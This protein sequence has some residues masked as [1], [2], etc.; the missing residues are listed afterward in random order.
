MADCG[1][2]AW[3]HGWNS[4]WPY[5]RPNTTGR[6]ATRA[7]SPGALPETPI[8]D[9]SLAMDL[10]SLTFEEV[11]HLWG[12]LGAKQSP[13]A[14]YRGRLVTLADM[15][16]LDGGGIVQEIDLIGRGGTV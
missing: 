13:F 9:F 6:K 12:F 10:L 8:V 5:P 3:K 16:V 14:L 15:P 7:N 2:T 11:N 4:F 1:T